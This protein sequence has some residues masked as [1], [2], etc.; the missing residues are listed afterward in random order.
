[1]LPKSN[2]APHQILRYMPKEAHQMRRDTPTM[3]DVHT[4]R[5]PVPRSR[6]R[7]LDRRHDEHSPLRHAEAEKEAHDQS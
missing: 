1:M 3:S 6:L 7:T 5:P 2:V 4:I